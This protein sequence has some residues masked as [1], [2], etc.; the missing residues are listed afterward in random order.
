M[1][2]RK[3]ARALGV[4][5]EVRAEQFLVSRGMRILERNARLAGAEID[6]IARDADTVVFIE[7][8]ARSEARGVP[9]RIAVT[10]AKQRRISRGALT[11]LARNGLM[12]AKARFDVIEIQGER[13]T[14]IPNAFPYQGPAY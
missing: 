1:E 4:L 13:V 11:Y 8:K 5:G 10:P 6:L 12:G 9:G 3:R 2:E 14:H 7:V